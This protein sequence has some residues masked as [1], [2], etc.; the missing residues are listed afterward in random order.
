[1]SDFVSKNICPITHIPVNEIY[2]T[3]TPVLAPD[4]YTY[5]KEA[6]ERWVRDHGNSPVTRE[7]M[8]FDQLTINRALIPG[9]SSSSSSSNEASVFVLSG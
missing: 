6:I 9:D 4:G 5:E 2:K 3:S 7:T 1:M 8:R